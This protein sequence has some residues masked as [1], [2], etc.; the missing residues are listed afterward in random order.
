V[1][2][3]SFVRAF[4]AFVTTDSTTTLMVVAVVSL[5]IFSNVLPRCQFHQA[6][7]AKCEC[8]GAS[9]AVMLVTTDRVTPNPTSDAKNTQKSV[10]LKVH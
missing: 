2:K 5:I 4:S 3:F 6:F 9:D 1:R 8:F 7:G 10:N